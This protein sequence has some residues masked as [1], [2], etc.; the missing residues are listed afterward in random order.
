ME[1]RFEFDAPVGE[2]MMRRFWGV[3]LN[4][5]DLW[6]GHEEKKWLESTA[7]STGGASNWDHAPRTFK[8][9]K[10]YLKR[11]PELS[12]C[13]EVT[14]GSLFVGHDIRAYPAPPKA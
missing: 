13:Q 9:F 3:T 2:R 10:R 6:F 5:D 8:A 7:Q 4:K 11:H 12:A 1:W 14:L